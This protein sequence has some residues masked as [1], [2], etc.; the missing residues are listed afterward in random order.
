MTED[1]RYHAY[2][3]LYEVQEWLEE[4][5]EELEDLEAL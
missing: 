1:D 3:T 4:I 2:M 5:R